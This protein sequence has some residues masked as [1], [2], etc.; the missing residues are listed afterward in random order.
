[1]FLNGL[2]SSRLREV[3]YRSDVVGTGCRYDRVERVDCGREMSRKSSI[4][5]TK[6]MH[7]SNIKYR[8]SAVIPPPSIFR[9]KLASA[10]S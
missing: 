10:D 9:E 4:S 6:S 5:P 3:E 8:T 1:M 7:M 2:V